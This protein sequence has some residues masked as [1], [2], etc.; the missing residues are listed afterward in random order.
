MTLTESASHGRTRICSIEGSGI[1]PEACTALFQPFSQADTSTT[2]K[3]GGTGL[4]LVIVKQ[5]VEA[6]GGSVRLESD[7]EGRGT[8]V[9]ISVPRAASPHAPYA[10][11]ATPPQA[12]PTDA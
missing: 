1:S 5:L 8:T 2:R 3:F 10:L 6:M 4:G 9:S 7:G 11:G 12:P